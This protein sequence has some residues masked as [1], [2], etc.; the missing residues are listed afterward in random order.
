MMAA[1]ISGASTM[2]DVDTPPEESNTMGDD[3]AEQ[4]DG[5]YGEEDLEEGELD[6]SFL[7][8]DAQDDAATPPA[9]AKP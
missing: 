9:E 2:A 7:D 5:Y 4:A 6:L 8:E 1:N 3:Q